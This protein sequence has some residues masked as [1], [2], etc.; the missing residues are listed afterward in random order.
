MSF[1]KF[2]KVD[3]V[4]GIEAISALSYFLNRESELKGKREV[5]GHL[6]REREVLLEICSKKE[7]A[8]RDDNSNPISISYV[9][10]ISDFSRRLRGL[11]RDTKILFRLPISFLAKVFPEEI[12]PLFESVGSFYMN[13]FFMNLSTNMSEAI[14]S[15]HNSV[16]IRLRDVLITKCFPEIALFSSTRHGGDR[17]HPLF[18][19]LLETLRGA[20]SLSS[21]DILKMRREIFNRAKCETARHDEIINYAKSNDP[22]IVLKEY[23]AWREKLSEYKE[24]LRGVLL[25]CRNIVSELL[26]LARHSSSTT[27][28]AAKTPAAV[29]QLGQVLDLSDPSL[30]YRTVLEY[31]LILLSLIE[32]LDRINMGFE[33]K[34]GRD[35]KFLEYLAISEVLD[36]LIE[37][38]KLERRERI[39]NSSRA[40]SKRNKSKAKLN[41][42]ARRKQDKSFSKD[43][44]PPSVEVSA[45]AVSKKSVSKKVTA[46]EKEKTRQP[47]HLDFV[48]CDLPNTSD[49]QDLEFHLERA[50]I[51]FQEVMMIAQSGQK[52]GLHLSC[53]RL[54][55]SMSLVLELNGQ[56]FSSDP[57]HDL[58][59]MYSTYEDESMNDF[60]A[61]FKFGSLE[62]RYPEGYRY[63][64]QL[65][66]V[67]PSIISDV[68]M[69]Q[70]PKWGDLKAKSKK[71]CLERIS[72]AF[73]SFL[74]VMNKDSKHLK[75]IVEENKAVLD[76]MDPAVLEKKSESSM[77]EA[78]EELVM[79]GVLRD[80][81]VRFMRVNTG[82]GNR[83]GMPQ[84]TL[85]N[86]IFQLDLIKDGLKLGQVQGL[87]N[88]KVRLIPQLERASELVLELL[89]ILKGEKLRSHNFGE[90]KEALKDV[91]SPEG[92][93]ALDQLAE[94]NFGNHSHYLHRN[95]GKE[96]TKA[97]KHFDTYYKLQLS[98]GADLEKVRMLSSGF[99]Q[100]VKS[101]AE[102]VNEVL[103]FQMNRDPQVG[104][105]NSLLGV[106]R[107]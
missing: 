95:F 56:Q 33:S 44:Q 71:K 47:C 59:D 83:K 52:D 74:R 19:R 35:S 9:C 21:S 73:E 28:L 46:S 107:V 36:E 6:L 70:L 20:V 65:G 88:S 5:H 58:V 57:N 23:R 27:A 104:E 94:F 37:E 76:R 42:K 106:L 85:K 15:Q 63:Y 1:G 14:I 97:K 72:K 30:L 45:S 99:D 98:E 55:H 50:F 12:N 86:V 26:P 40:V 60:F 61:E 80:D 84:T 81:L 41:A 13:N 4:G 43:P 10:K 31:D 25:E 102:L 91:L 100:S 3:D 24:S 78:S 7:L 16:V 34:I 62:A 29:A 66:G 38:R 105:I 92:I 11:E 103:N 96:G 48:T 77:E 90:Y 53:Q 67:A 18:G 68:L 22:V 32:D 64:R 89:T 82:L 39:A 54:F 17:L 79:C 93:K 101:L 75:A 69:N 87:E 2:L 8:L 51:S 49:Q